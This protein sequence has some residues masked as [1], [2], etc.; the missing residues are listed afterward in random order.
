MNKQA[1]YMGMMSGTST[2]GID[3]VLVS[4]S[5]K[6]DQD[7]KLKCLAHEY[8]KIDDEW[9]DILLSLNVSGDNELE[10]AA[11]ASIHLGKLHVALINR[12]LEKSS[13]TP[14]SITAVGVHGQTVRHRPDLGY[15]IQ[16]NAP[17]YIAQHSGI[18][19]VADFRSADVALQGQGAPFAPL[20]HHMI[21]S[22][23]N[24]ESEMVLNLGGIANV[25]VYPRGM[26]Q[27]DCYG[28]DTGPAN[29]LL[30][31]W[32]Q[33]VL[34]Q[35]YDEAGQW[36]SKGQVNDALLN[37]LYQREPWFELTAPK[38]TGRDQFNLA[39]LEQAL[40]DF[41]EEVADV[42]V[43]ATLY[44]LTAYSIMRSL[45]YQGIQKGRLLICGGGAKNPLLVQYIKQYSEKLS[46]QLSIQTSDEI[47]IPSHVIEAA[48]FAYLAYLH[49]EKIPV[50]TRKLTGALHPY[51]LGAFY[52]GFL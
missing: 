6:Y 26:A 45:Q 36:G 30:D 40:V 41:S 9:R 52:P 25:S 5:G 50:D 3:G 32:I 33:K 18:N 38:S 22:G 37:F 20:F 11:L 44:G 47:G 19:V 17:A 8:V 34:A 16:L 42:D 27:K 24:E 39:W 31:A 1:Y 14:S 35:P 4:I 29:M 12:L 49:M 10:K 21:F 7:L 43:M 28:Y 2:D 15:T 13:L 46:L 51:I 48:G 23:S